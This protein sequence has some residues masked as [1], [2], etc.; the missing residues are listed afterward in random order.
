MRRGHASHGGQYPNGIVV[1]TAEREVGEEGQGGNSKYP[2]Q[3]DDEA[4]HPVI[5]AA[6]R[7]RIPDARGVARSLSPLGER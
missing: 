6:T 5:I 2:E 7:P 1:G 4:P 3:K